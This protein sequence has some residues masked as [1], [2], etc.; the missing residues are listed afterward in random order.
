LSA[1]SGSLD[2]SGSVYLDLD[3]PDFS[4]GPLSLS[5]IVVG[6]TSSV[7]VEPKE[8]V[9]GLLPIVPTTSRDFLK[10][11]HATVF[12][13]LYEPG[14]SVPI[15][16]AVRIANRDQRLL[17]DRTETIGQ[18]RF[19]AAHAADYRLDLPL[20]TLASG[21]YLLTLEATMGTTTMRRDVRFSVR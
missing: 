1:H 17:V 13:R 19:G 11:D 15:V 8:I 21:P 9:A 7:P 4:K 12:M 14:K 3:V 2:K 16:L 20:D 10:S 6:V 18:D 5:G